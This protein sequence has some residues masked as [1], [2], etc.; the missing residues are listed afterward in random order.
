M[1]LTLG[2]MDIPSRRQPTK[3]TEQFVESQARSKRVFRT[4]WSEVLINAAM[5]LPVFPPD[6]RSGDAW[7]QII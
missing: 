2:P 7:E 5:D 1:G 3:I 6:H 4:S